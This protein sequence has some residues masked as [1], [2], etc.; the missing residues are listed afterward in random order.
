[1]QACFCSCTGVVNTT[2]VSSRKEGT[3]A[4][5]KTCGGRPPVDGIGSMSA[6]MISAKGLE[7]T[8]F[9]NPDLTWKTVSKGYRSS[10]RRSRKPIDRSPKSDADL[11]DKGEDTIVS[12]SEKVDITV[13]PLKVALFLDGLFSCFLGL[14]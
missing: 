3:T 8:N 2:L 4:S 11:Q 1:M 9:I 13:F 12:E 14:C 7:L 5:C 6:S 10:T